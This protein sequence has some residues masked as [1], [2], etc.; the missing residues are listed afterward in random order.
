MPPE[1][2]A[3]LLAIFDRLPAPGEN[4]RYGETPGWDSLGQLRLVAEIEARLHCV[5]STDDIL[6][7][8]SLD[9]LN[10]LW[11]QHSL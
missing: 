5:L 8:R 9:R 3:T 7:L 11:E 2:E 1:L 6:G 4:W 10:Q